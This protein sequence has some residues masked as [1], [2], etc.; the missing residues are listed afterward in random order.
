MLTKAGA[1]VGDA[2]V[3]T[4]PL[5]FGTTTTALKREQADP[6][7]VLEVVDW[8]KRLERP[9]FA[10]GGGIRGEGLHRYHRLQPGR[11]RPGACPRER[12]GFAESSSHACRS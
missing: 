10:A 9:G 3:L 7:D 11:A 1:K 4:K 2:L 5:G 8:M 6:A 12:G